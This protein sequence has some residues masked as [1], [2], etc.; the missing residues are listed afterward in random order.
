MFQN[1]QIIKSVKHASTDTNEL[2]LQAVFEKD[3][4]FE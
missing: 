4:L 2:C 3:L 1:N